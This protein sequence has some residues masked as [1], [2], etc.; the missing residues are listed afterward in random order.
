MS[1]A[2]DEHQCLLGT[3]SRKR[4]GYGLCLQELTSGFL[5]LRALHKTHAWVVTFSEITGQYGQASRSRTCTPKVAGDPR[6]GFLVVVLI[7]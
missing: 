1:R 4:M 6:C 5:L 7:N 3:F 2:I